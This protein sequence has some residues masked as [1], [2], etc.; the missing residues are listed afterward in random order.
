[1]NTAACVSVLEVKVEVKVEMEVKVEAEVEKE[2]NMEGMKVEVEGLVG[3]SCQ[4]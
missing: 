3:Q 4:C 1:M 2:L